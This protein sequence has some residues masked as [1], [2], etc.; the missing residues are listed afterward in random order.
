MKPEDLYRVVCR[1]A[2][3]KDTQDVL[4][5]T[6]RIW[7][8]SDYV[9][10]VWEEWLADSE[11]ILAVAEYAGR[12]VGLAKL[13]RL[14]S[15]DWWLQGLRVDPDYRGRGIARR[16]HEYALDAWLRTGSGK[17]RLTTNS[18]NYP[19]HHL[20]EATGMHRLGEYLAYAAPAMD[21][22]LQG[23]DKL[24][25][26]RLDAALDFITHSPT[27]KLSWD[28]IDLE[29]IWAG[30]QCS[31]L[32]ELVN[33]GLVWTR[34]NGE[35]ILVGSRDDDDRKKRAYL[36]LAACE[37]EDLPGCLLD[38][39][40]LA[41]IYGLGMARWIAP[42]Q[43]ELQAALEQAGYAPEWDH[44]LF[45]YEIEHPSEIGGMQML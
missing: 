16:L 2:L 31:Y 6:A 15:K 29:W 42:L 8:G 7:E 34:D 20:C 5:F 22:P 18:N 41:S 14:S 19:V 21:E 36:Q 17:L 13:V 23:W 28:L 27:F 12:S 24:S 33:R 44:T 3:S 30:L 39:R 9:P 35:G 11:G 10:Y 26:E 4:T 25:P 40:R 1:P 37:L 32:E 38:F 43:P 45:L